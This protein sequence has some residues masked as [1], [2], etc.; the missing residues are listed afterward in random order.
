MKRIKRILLTGAVPLA[1]LL[2]SWLLFAFLYQT[3]NKYTQKAS[4]PI[5]G[6]LSLSEKDLRQAP[7]RYLIREWEFYPD[8]LFTPQTFADK[9]PGTYRQYISVGQY[10]GMEAGNIHRSPHGIGTYRLTIQLPKGMRTYALE[11]PEIFSAY[12]FYIN[13]ELK[14]QSGDPNPESY[15]PCIKEKTVVFQ[16]EGTINL[17]LA[18]S[19]FSWIYSGLTYPPAFGLADAVINAREN[20]LLIRMAALLLGFLGLILSLYL[21]FRAHWKKGLLY[22]LQCIFY[23]GYTAFPLLHRFFATDVN[24][25]YALQLFCFYAMLLMAVLLQNSLCQIRGKIAGIW[26]F[27]CAAGTVAAFLTG[28]C[29]SR[30]GLTAFY[31][32][33]LLSAVLKYG[34]AVYL[35]IVSGVAV[36]N[37][38]R[39]SL[40]LLYTSEFFAVSLLADWL[41]PLF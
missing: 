26:P 19:D 32:F 20:Y 29:A 38:R 40:L 33:S 6:I 1:I 27:I 7:L 25:W 18:V 34:S 13:Q 31:S 4:Q 37:R 16:G 8:V 23:L 17:L 35:L 2:S 11:L 3:D 10:G 15:T 24:P 41:M 5:C 12:A 39:F 22:A 21:G 9:K 28:I 14:A 36:R 30:L